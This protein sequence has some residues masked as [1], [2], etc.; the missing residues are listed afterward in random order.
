MVI[1]EITVQIWMNFGIG[2]CSKSCMADLILVRFDLA[3]LLCMTLRSSSEFLK[4]WI[5][6]YTHNWNDKL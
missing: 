3:G 4:E 1:S 5:I 2:V 6:I